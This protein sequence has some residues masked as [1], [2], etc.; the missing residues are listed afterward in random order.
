M[1]CMAPLEK[2]RL[3]GLA[4]L[5]ARLEYKLV[6]TSAHIWQLILVRY[7]HHSEYLL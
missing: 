6:G 1:K 4:I 5:T 7:S 2:Q 3:G